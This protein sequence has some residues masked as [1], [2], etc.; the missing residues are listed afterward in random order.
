MP[1]TH[2]TCLTAFIISL[3][4]FAFHR[5][6]LIATLLCL[7]SMTLTMFTSL[8]TW[9]LQLQTPSLTLP[10]I[11][12]LTLSACDTSTGLSL[13]VASSRTHGLDSL[14]TLNLLKC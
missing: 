6:H 8:A 11:L 4:G 5:K 14:K 2:F 3:V 9:P 12:V 1:L 10:P 7:E 13:M